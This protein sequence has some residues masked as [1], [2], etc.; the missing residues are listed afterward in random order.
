MKYL[1]LYESF[2]IDV[3]GFKEIS[4]DSYYEYI[5]KEEILDKEEFS[6]K[7]LTRIK[8]VINLNPEVIK[9]VIDKNYYLDIYEDRE[10]GIKCVFGSQVKL[11]SICMYKLTDTW[12]YTRVAYYETNSMVEITK[13]FKCDGFKGLIKNIKYGLSLI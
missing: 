4:K 11:S 13:Y 9:S 12:Y 5:V 2:N 1:K 8:S 3:D 7:E 6:E 10:L